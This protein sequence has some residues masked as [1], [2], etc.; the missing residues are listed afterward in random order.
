MSYGFLIGLAVPYFYTL[1]S[2]RRVLF[3]VV[4]PVQSDVLVV[5]IES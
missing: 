5:L 2:D 1:I 4:I 3:R